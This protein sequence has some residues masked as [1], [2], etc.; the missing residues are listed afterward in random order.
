M[1]KRG[2]GEDSVYKQ[3]NGLW[4]ARLQLEGISGKLSLHLL[5]LPE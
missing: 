5:W 3:R 2:N 1:A 4:A